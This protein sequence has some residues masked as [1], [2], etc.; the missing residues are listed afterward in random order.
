MIF[1]SN[2]QQDDV[3]P[4]ARTPEAHARER[5]DCVAHTASILHPCVFANAHCPGGPLAFQGPSS[6]GPACRRWCHLPASASPQPQVLAEA[7]ILPAC[8]TSSG[9]QSVFA[10][11]PA[12]RFPRPAHSKERV[13]DETAAAKPQ[14]GGAPVMLDGPIDRQGGLAWRNA[15][16]ARNHGYAGV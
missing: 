2:E 12:S 1:P 8:P 16:I 6:R 14:N 15:Q 13:G 7:S 10:R 3:M 11:R 9:W 4:R 5:G